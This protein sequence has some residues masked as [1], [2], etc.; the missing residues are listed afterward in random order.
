MVRELK[1]LAKTQIDPIKPI[2]PEG[3]WL[4]DAERGIY[5]L[6]GSAGTCLPGRSRGQGRPDPEGHQSD[7][8]T[9]GHRRQRI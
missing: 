2:M 8:R 5:G 7:S 6:A 1:D 3:T 4:G 9:P